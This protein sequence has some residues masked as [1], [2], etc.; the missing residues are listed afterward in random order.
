MWAL[1]SYKRRQGL[2]IVFVVIFVCSVFVFSAVVVTAFGFIVAI[3]HFAVFTVVVFFLAVVFV[4]LRA[5]V[6]KGFFLVIDGWPV[7][8]RPTGRAAATDI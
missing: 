2:Q 3:V 4:E 1:I 5:R 6:G 7:P 8:H